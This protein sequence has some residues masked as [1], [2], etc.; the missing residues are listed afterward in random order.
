M[1]NREDVHNLEDLEDSE[2]EEDVED[3]AVEEDLAPPAQR[4]RKFLAR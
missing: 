1:V 4:V 3:I 2:D